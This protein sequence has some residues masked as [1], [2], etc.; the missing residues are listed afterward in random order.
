MPAGNPALDKRFDNIA[1][2]S[3]GREGQLELECN[4]AV[5]RKSKLLVERFR[6]PA[7]RSRRHRPGAPFVAMAM[8]LDTWEAESAVSIHADFEHFFALTCTARGGKHFCNGG[9][10]ET[11]NPGK[12][13]R[14]SRYD[15]RSAM[16][17]D[18]LL[19]RIDDVTFWDLSD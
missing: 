16:F 10:L 5:N 15:R 14:M 19:T 4:V 3:P 7:Y 9:C 6:V 1:R 12:M 18:R 8:L 11:P 17:R 2:I 13:R